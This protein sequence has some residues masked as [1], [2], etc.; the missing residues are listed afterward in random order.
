MKWE[1]GAD[2][3]TIL[4][5]CIETSILHRGLYS[6]L[7]GDLNTKGRKTPKKGICVYLELIHFVVQQKLTESCTAT[8]L[9]HKLIFF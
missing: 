7:C 4:I 5:L 1:T 9:Q 2:T 6:M 3:Y 8:I